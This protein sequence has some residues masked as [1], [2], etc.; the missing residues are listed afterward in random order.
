VKIRITMK[1]PDCEYGPVEDAVKAELESVPGLSKDEREALMET[2][3]ESARAKLDKWM[4]YG[5]YLTVEFDTEAGTATV[6]P[7]E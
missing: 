2:R 6:I 7:K 4:K 1:D 5:E 3:C